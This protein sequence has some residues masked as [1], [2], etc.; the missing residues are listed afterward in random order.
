M[1]EVTSEDWDKVI[2]YSRCVP[3]M[4]ESDFYVKG[5]Y[6]DYVNCFELCEDEVTIV[7]VL[8]QLSGYI[9]NCKELSGSDDRTATIILKSNGTFEMVIDY[10]EDRLTDSEYKSKWKAD[11]LV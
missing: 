4:Q 5:Q 7:N 6:K 2:I 9:N 8:L 3:G 1:L 11:Y 10:N